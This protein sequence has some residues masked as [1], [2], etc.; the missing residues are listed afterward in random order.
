MR[1]LKWLSLVV[2]AFVVLGL[3]GV[4]VVLL[5]GVIN[6]AVAV[7]PD[8]GAVQRAGSSKSATGC[9]K[10]TGRLLKIGYRM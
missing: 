3:P 10:R 4:A 6:R 5:V 1:L 7:R 9:R 8:G 2:V